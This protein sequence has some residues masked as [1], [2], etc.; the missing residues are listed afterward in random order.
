MVR[1]VKGKGKG[2]DDERCKGKG[3]DDERLEEDK[4]KGKKGEREVPRR[5]FKGKG[6]GKA[7]DKGKVVGEEVCGVG[8]AA[9]GGG[10]GAAAR[11]EEDEGA[12]VAARRREGGWSKGEGAWRHNPHGE[13]LLMQVPVHLQGGDFERARLANKFEHL[14]ISAVG[15]TFLKQMNDIEGIKFNLRGS[16]MRGSSLLIM[17]VR[18]LHPQEASR[19]LLDKLRARCILGLLCAQEAGE[20]LDEVEMPAFIK[21]GRVGLRSH[22]RKSIIISAQNGINMLRPQICKI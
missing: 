5:H 9:R 10:A 3:K 11:Q 12:G 22:Q 18:T 17:T 20:D 8:V 14:G 13:D 21:N 1:F 4:G 6:K 19:E 7:K 16:R 15:P 2:K